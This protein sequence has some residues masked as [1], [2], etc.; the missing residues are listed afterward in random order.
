MTDKERRKKCKELWASETE[1]TKT[2]SKCLKIKS[3]EDFSPLFKG[4][5]GLQTHCKICHRNNYRKKQCEQIIKQFELRDQENEDEKFCTAC[6]KIKS[7]SNFYKNS[8]G[9]KGVRSTCI[10]CLK[11]KL[12]EGY[13]PQAARRY[14]LK[15]KYNITE[16]DYDDLLKKQNNRCAICGVNKLEYTDKFCIDHNHITGEVRALLCS[17][18]NKGLGF[19]RDDPTTLR[20][21]AIYLDIH[22]KVPQRNS[23]ISMLEAY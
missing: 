18:C 10:Q 6:L 21:A 13:N 15:N 4:R 12:K 14:E 2:C 23:S 11:A 20:K 1:T 19:F 5:K 8:V 3:I 17:N 22:N 16:E 9:R 7:L